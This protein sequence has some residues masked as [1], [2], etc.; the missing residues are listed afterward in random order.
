MSSITNELPTLTK[1][2]F[3]ILFDTGSTI[4]FIHPKLV[5]EKNCKLYDEL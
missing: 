5:K 4:N 3:T 2:P 1:G